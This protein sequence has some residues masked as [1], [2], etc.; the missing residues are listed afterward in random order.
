MVIKRNQSFKAGILFALKI[1]GYFSPK[2]RHKNFMIY[3]FY[4]SPN[5]VDEDRFIGLLPK[6][7]KAPQRITHQ[8]IMNW[9]KL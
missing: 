2:R 6:R 3:E 4:W 1:S 7:R 9:A 5:W 8:S